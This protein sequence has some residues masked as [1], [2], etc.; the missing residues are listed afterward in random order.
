MPFKGDTVIGRCFPQ[1]HRQHFLTLLFGLRVRDDLLGGWMIDYSLK[2][3]SFAIVL[4]L[5]QTPVILFQ[6]G[7]GVLLGSII[8]CGSACHHCTQSWAFLSQIDESLDDQVLIYYL[9]SPIALQRAVL[10]RPALPQ[11]KVTHFT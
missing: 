3:L 7:Q 11:S 2:D 8:G 4:K 5:L 9:N 6:K 1:Q 10:P